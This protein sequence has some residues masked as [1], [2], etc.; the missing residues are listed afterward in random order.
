MANKYFIAGNWKMHFTP[1]QAESFTDKLVKK[2]SKDV[3]CDVVI[4]PNFVSLAGVARAVKDSPIKVA[5]QNLYFQ[6]EGAFTG[7]TS[8][9]MLKGIANYVIIGH[10]ERR[11]IFNE[12]EV[13]ISKKIDAAIRNGIKPIL[14]VGET[15]L[16]RQ[17]G[18]TGRVLH[19]QVTVGLKGLTSREISKV[20]I[21]Y[22]P[23]WAIGTG[24]IA[25][26]DQV[27]AAVA[28]I[29]CNVG[30]LYGGDIADKTRVLYGGSATAAT[31]P[32]YLNIEGIDGLLIGG[33]SLNV[34]SFVQIV[35]AADKLS[36]KK[37]E[38]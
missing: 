25:K 34:D 22:E 1:S 18:H 20:V 5:A 2:I 31:A 7:E 17:S 28:K 9:L 33:A 16:E 19:E 24:N 26:P 4:S 12:D 37:G 30:E 8:A 27:A 29:R 3:K 38:I 10:S 32:G 14:C 13:M 36:S 6:D 11:H 15:L 21:A 23:V 35:E